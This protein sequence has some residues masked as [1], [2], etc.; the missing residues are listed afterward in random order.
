VIAKEEMIDVLHNSLL[1]VIQT[2][3]TYSISEP[4]DD[5]R[6]NSACIG[7]LRGH[8]LVNL[9]SYFCFSFVVQAHNNLTE[10]SPIKL[11]QNLVAVSNMITYDY[12]I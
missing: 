9:D 7:M 12:L 1:V 6:F 2:F 5:G 3:I 4:L 8:A 11:L 10:S